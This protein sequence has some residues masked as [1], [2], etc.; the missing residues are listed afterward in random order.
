MKYEYNEGALPVIVCER[1]P[2][3]K[4]IYKSVWR[5]AFK[6]VRYPST[7]GWK[8]YL[9]A[10]SDSNNIWVCDSNFMVFFSRYS[11]GTLPGINDLDN[12]YRL[13]R[14]DGYISMAYNP[15]P[16][17]EAYPGR[18]MMPIFA[19]TEWEYYLFTGDS[20]RFERVLPV[21]ARYFDW[22]KA[23]RRRPNGLYWYEDSGSSG[24]DNSPRGGYPSLHQ[25]GSDICFIDLACQQ[26]LGA[27]H[28]KNIAGFLGEKDVAERFETEHKELVAL[29]NNKHW[30]D[31]YGF[32]Y[33]LNYKSNE[34]RNYYQNHKTG[35][36]FWA[37]LCGAADADIWRFGKMI[38]HIL[39]P[40]EFWTKNPVPGLSRD[41]PNYDPLGN[42]HCGSVWSNM[43]YMVAAGL[44]TCG[45]MDIAREIAV[46]HLSSIEKVWKD[47]AWGNIWEAYSPEYDRPASS[48]KGRVVRANNVGCTGLVPISMLIEFILGFGFDA[49]KNTISW[50]IS[51]NGKHGISNLKFNGQKVSLIAEAMNIKKPG[52]LITV[53][54]EK[55]FILDVFSEGALLP[56]QK[57]L[58]KLAPGRHELFVP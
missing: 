39:N 32:Y 25:D 6:N 36:A 20:S 50:L 17:R 54:N 21:L 18:I 8:P 1:H 35:A 43:D 37:L 12:F 34:T 22:I 26:A 40:E 10:L 51:E 58:H 19:W 30:G 15:E 38:E 13:Q 57:R 7:K 33:D 46:K 28:I 16:E 3:W 55:A 5:M 23:N 56:V 45:R 29:I 31:R 24:F 14:E 53:E 2:E 27:L 48:S 44:R 47:E 42:Y 41:D 9:A 11:D 49:G 52:R 4:E